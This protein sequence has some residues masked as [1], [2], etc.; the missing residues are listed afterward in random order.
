MIDAVNL[1]APRPAYQGGMGS[2]EDC[3][4]NISFLAI[5]ANNFV[6]VPAGKS[7]VVNIKR[8]IG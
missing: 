1:K 3:S 2:G 6:F 7:K 5:A 8:P 4:G